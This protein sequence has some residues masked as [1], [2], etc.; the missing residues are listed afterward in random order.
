MSCNE[1]RAVGSLMFLKR[2][3]GEVIALKPQ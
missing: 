3:S 2:D 1:V